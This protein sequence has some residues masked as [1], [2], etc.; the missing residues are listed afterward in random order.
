[1][2][3]SKAL[4]LE[5]MPKV[6]KNIAQRTETDYLG[7]MRYAALSGMTVPEAMKSLRGFYE[8]LPEGGLIV[9]ISSAEFPYMLQFIQ[10]AEDWLGKLRTDRK[11]VKIVCLVDPSCL[12]E[13]IRDDSIERLSGY[14]IPLL[15]WTENSVDYWCKAK[16]LPGVNSKELMEKTGGWHI[17]TYPTLSSGKESNDSP[18][19]EDF[20]PTVHGLSQLVASLNELGGEACPEEDIIE[21][22]DIPDGMTTAEFR[23]WLE[24]LKNLYVLRESSGGLYL[25]PVAAQII[26]GDFR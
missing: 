5:L 1:M 8:K 13:F 20:I 24:L 7:K 15:P 16:T 2:S 11:Y 9:S 26:A 12:C 23:F 3:G 4:G 18:R 22:I 6:L 17:L 10:S 14:H 21:L 19:P 25:E